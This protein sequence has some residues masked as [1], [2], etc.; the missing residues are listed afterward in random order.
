MVGSCVRLRQ[1]DRDHVL[2][3]GKGSY[4]IVRHRTEFKREAIDP[5]DQS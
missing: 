4:D 5:G 2:L 1:E 3:S